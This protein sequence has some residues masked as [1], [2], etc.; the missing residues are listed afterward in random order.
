M[1]TELMLARSENK[2]K[3]AEVA[4][5]IQCDGMSDME[6]HCSGAAFALR[7]LPAVLAAVAGLTLLMAGVTFS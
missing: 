3:L 6:A 7:W 5:S 1:L 2:L 4:Q